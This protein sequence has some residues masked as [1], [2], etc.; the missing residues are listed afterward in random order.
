[1]IAGLLWNPIQVPWS[2]EDKKKVHVIC[3]NIVPLVIC[4]LISRFVLLD[5]CSQ[6]VIKLDQGSSTINQ[7][8]LVKDGENII[9]NCLF[10]NSHHSHCGILSPL[11]L[12]FVFFLGINGSSFGLQLFLY[13][14]F[15]PTPKRHASL[16]ALASRS[17]LSQC[18]RHQKG[19]PHEVSHLLPL[20]PSTTKGRR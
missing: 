11:S 12:S 17:Q 16:R 7:V 14:A 2:E 5:A 6:E 1:M 3:L 10:F 8:K 20:C 4:L 15:S 19:R 18:Q 13:I 9:K